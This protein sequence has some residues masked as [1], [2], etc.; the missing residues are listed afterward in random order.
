VSA[1]GG[2]AVSS[3]EAIQK[4]YVRVPFFNAIHAWKKFVVFTERIPQN[5]SRL[6]H[7]AQSQT[8]IRLGRCVNWIVCV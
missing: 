7:F 8:F 2:A 5:T 4:D 3:G 6:S 1:I